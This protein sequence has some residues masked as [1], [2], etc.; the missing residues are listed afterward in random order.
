M[1]NETAPT[2]CGAHADQGRIVIGRERPNEGYAVIRCGNTEVKVSY[3]ILHCLELRI[4]GQSS[5]FAH[6]CDLQRALR[7]I[8]CEASLGRTGE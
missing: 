6:L 8:T 3:T 7:S 1:H 2:F 5:N 4:D